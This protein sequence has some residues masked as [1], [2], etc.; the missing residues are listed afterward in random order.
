MGGFRNWLNQVKSGISRGPTPTGSWGD[1]EKFGRFEGTG[2]VNAELSLPAGPLAVS[3]ED[4]L[5]VQDLEAELTGSSG[6]P[7]ELK[8]YSE[9]PDDDQKKAL[10]YIRRVASA[11]IEAPGPYRLT[12]KAPNSAAPLLILVGED[13][14]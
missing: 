10:K 9:A 7:L 4:Y 12:V 3:I 14:G 5:T 2:E 13:G 1:L 11:R 6:E 8:H